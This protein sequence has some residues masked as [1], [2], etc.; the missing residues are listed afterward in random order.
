LFQATD[1]AC[2]APYP[3]PPCFFPSPLHLP[4][5]RRRPQAAEARGL[6][7]IARMCRKAGLVVQ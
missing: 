4:P 1:P 5:G 6:Y 3:L 7:K 2:A